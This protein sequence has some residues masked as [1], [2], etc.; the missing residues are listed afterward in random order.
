[1]PVD[2]FVHASKQGPLT[3]C[4]NGLDATLTPTGVIV[5][6][7]GPTAVNKSSRWALDRVKSNRERLLVVCHGAM[8]LESVALLVVVVGLV[9][10]L[11]AT[12]VFPER[13]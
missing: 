13:F 8:T 11:L 4:V 2:E 1:M 9:G 12:L 7:Q 5:T 6:D 3:T 10:Y